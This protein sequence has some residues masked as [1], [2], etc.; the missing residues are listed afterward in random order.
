MTA[1]I[2]SIQSINCSQSNYRKGR[3]YIENLSDNP[4]EKTPGQQILEAFKNREAMSFV[5]E[6]LL[7][8]SKKIFPNHTQEAED[9]IESIFHLVSL[10]AHMSSKKENGCLK[11]GF[12][13]IH[14]QIISNNDWFPQAYNLYREERAEKDFALIS[15]H[16]KGGE[17][18][19]LGCGMGHLSVQ[20]SENGFTVTPADVI[21]YENRVSREDEKMKFKKMSSPTDLDYSG[22]HFDTIIIWQVLHHINEEDLF[23][24][25][26]GLSKIGH[27]LIIN[28]EIY[29]SG[30]GVKGFSQSIREQKE[31]AR[32]M[33]LEEKDQ[34]AIL[35]II[36]NISNSVVRLSADEM[37]IPLRF[38]P[39][40]QWQ[41]ILPKAGFDIE[42][43]YSIG[44]KEY[45]WH[46]DPQILI[47]ADSQKH[48]S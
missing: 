39:V 10:M 27:R 4:G 29:G 11:D 28:E 23:P 13:A 42:G 30:D 2:E 38:K 45:K 15:P 24:I 8:K 18:L 44:I 1:H 33:T 36:D 47:I 22:K 25:L 5:R 48:K 17:I 3:Q 46:P 7:M 9:M 12:T 41:T 40:D 14:K 21:D 6:N 26:S 34:I 43:I 37:N 20:L 31:F 19:D 16:L 35:Q 32:Y